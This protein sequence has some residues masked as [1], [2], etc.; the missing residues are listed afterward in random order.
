MAVPGPIDLRSDHLVLIVGYRHEEECG[1][2]DLSAVFAE[3][4]QELRRRVD[5]IWPRAVAEERRN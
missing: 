2:C 4:D 3:G 1:C 5:A